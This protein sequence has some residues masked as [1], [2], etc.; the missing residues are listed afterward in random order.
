MDI[1]FKDLHFIVLDDK[2]VVLPEG[3]G[4]TPGYDEGSVRN[5]LGLVD[6]QFPC[7]CKET[8]QQ[9]S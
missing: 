8:S 5:K 7:N 2:K 4:T 1:I 3:F 6:I 9:T